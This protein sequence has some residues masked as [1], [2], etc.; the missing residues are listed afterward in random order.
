MSAPVLPLAEGVPWYP[1][2]FDGKRS[3]PSPA[4]TEI[5]LDLLKLD[6]S[7]CVMEIGTGSGYQ[8][9]RLA[10]TGAEIHSIECEPFVDLT[11]VVGN[12]IYLHVGDGAEGLSGDKFTAI[13]ATCGVR[14]IPKAWVD[15]LVEA[16]RMVI[17]IG[18]EQVQRLTL[19]RK[20]K[21]AMVPERIAAYVRF[22]MMEEKPKCRG[23]K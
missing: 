6:R 14:E 21:G 19:Y 9:A 5:M 7:D 3:I 11:S 12:R 23:M 8:T 10:E 1:A 4:V 16:G 20:V 13:V 18:S 2:T 17:P 22:S 15:Q